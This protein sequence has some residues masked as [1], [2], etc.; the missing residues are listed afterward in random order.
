[1]QFNT[2]FGPVWAE[3]DGNGAVRQFGF[4]ENPSAGGFNE[5]VAIQVRE[6]FD[7]VRHSFVLPLAMRGTAF[8]LRVWAELQEIPYGTTITYRELGERAGKE[9]SA[10]AAARANATNPIALIV[11]CH[12]VVS[13]SGDVTGYL[14]GI[15]LKKKLLEFET[16]IR[17]ASRDAF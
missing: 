9:N 12:R 17:S 15:E 3:I 8:Q 13:A 16:R 1:M 4:G 5:E 6:Y 2:S 14:Y 7:G 10:R 11:P